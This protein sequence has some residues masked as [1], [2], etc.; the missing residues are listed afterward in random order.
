PGARGRGLPCPRLG[1]RRPGR[2]LLNHPNHGSSWVSFHGTPLAFLPSSMWGCRQRNGFTLV[3]VMV[4]ILIIGL[5]C[6]IGIP[7]FVKYQ[8]RSKT[9]EATMNLRKLFDA[10]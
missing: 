1:S 2:H 6:A 3:E 8:R 9:T 7:S 4:V 5:I 10:S